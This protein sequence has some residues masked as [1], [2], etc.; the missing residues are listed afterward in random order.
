MTLEGLLAVGGIVVAI[1]AI[2]QPVQR[3]SLSLFVPVW[4]VPAD[5]EEGLDLGFRSA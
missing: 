5:V 3:W 4:L 2:A 1:Y